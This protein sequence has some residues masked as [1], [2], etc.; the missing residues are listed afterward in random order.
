MALGFVVSFDERTL[1]FARTLHLVPRIVTVGIG[2]RKGTDLA[3]L[4]KEVLNVL[5]QAR[6]SPKAVAAIA[7]IDVKRDEPAILELA[8]ALGCDTRFYSAD[9]LASVQ[10]NFASSDF[11]EATV[12]VDNVCE[13]AACAHGAALIVGKHAR[14][15]VTV[16]CAAEWD[17]SPDAPRS[18][19]PGMRET[20][21]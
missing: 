13:R 16:A 18:N 6:I 19:G 9:E 2:C 5:A 4:R 7:S 12:G 17:S 8:Q 10:G 11:V 15:G 20:S 14:N 3:V 1:A 21:R